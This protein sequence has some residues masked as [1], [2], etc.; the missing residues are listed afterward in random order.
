MLLVI[1]FLESFVQK[2]VEKYMFLTLLLWNQN[3]LS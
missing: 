1:E 2:P 3:G